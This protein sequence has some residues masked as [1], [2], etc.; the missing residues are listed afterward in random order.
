M[1]TIAINLKCKNCYQIQNKLI[2]LTCGHSICSNCFI[3]KDK[4]LEW[5][6]N[7]NREDNNCKE[8]YFLNDLNK[9]LMNLKIIVS[10][11]WIYFMRCN[12]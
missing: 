7:F 12:D 9:K 8:K 11:Y 2:Q 4:C 5:D 3:A 1:E 10:Y 6:R